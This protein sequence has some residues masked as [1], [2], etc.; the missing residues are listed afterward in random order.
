MNNKHTKHTETE[1]QREYREMI[2]GQYGEEI[3]RLSLGRYVS[4]WQDWKEPLWGLFFETD[5]GLRFHYMPGESWVDVIFTF[6]KERKKP[7]EKMLFIPHENIIERQ[8]IKEKNFFKKLFG[9][10]PPYS[11]ISYTDDAG[12][13]AQLVIEVDNQYT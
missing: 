7:K 12:N 13:K 5:R 2:R 11:I 4:G 6:G 3:N 8:F 1:Q 10:R 9:S